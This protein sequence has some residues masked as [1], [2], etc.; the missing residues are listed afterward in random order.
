MQI[1]MHWLNWQPNYR[2][3][4]NVISPVE[5]LISHKLCRWQRAAPPRPVC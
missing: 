4:I 2:S 3:E 1:G 5:C